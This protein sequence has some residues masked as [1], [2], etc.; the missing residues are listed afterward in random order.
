MVV[1]VLATEAVGKPLASSTC[2]LRKLSASTARRL[3]S[4]IP[5]NSLCMASM[6]GWVGGLGGGGGGLGG[7]GGLGGRESPITSGPRDSAEGVFPEAGR[8]RLGGI[9]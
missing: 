2:A 7:A 9:T 1:G 3:L 5:S 6:S 4:L 8:S